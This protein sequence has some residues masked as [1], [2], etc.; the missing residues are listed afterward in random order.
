MANIKIHVLH[1]GSVIV[2]KNLPFHDNQANKLA[3]TGFLQPK[4]D[5]IEVPVSAYLIEHP[6]GLVLID[7]GWNTVN[8]SKWGQIKNLSFQYPVNKAKLPAGQAIN[9]QLSKLGYQTSDLDYVLLSHLHCDHAD[10]LR[11]VKDAKKIMTSQVELAAAHRDKFHYL[12]NEWRGVNIQPFELKSSGIGP[13]GRSFDLFGD[14][15]L[16]MVWVPGHAAGL[17]ATII[18]SYENDQTV[19]LTAD[20][21]YAHKSWKNNLRPSVVVN[22][23]Q[24]EQSLAWV[25]QMADNPTV[26]ETLANHDADVV[27]HTIVL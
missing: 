25:K 21:A 8:R 24:A 23:K 17:C 26:I 3:W 4:S 5:L 1:T 11:L 22:A 13:F 9:E 19:L 27:P 12:G 20:A 7:T 6:Q 16:E 2:N 14:G 15:S 10:G 18:R